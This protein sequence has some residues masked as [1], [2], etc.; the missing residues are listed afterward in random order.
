MMQINQLGNPITKTSDSVKRPDSM[1]SITNGSPDN[2][3][4]IIDDDV[5]VLLNS[6]LNLAVTLNVFLIDLK[7]SNIK[8]KSHDVQIPFE[9][10][11]FRQNLVSLEDLQKTIPEEFV[12]LHEIIQIVPNTNDKKSDLQLKRQKRMEE[13]QK[14]LAADHTQVAVKAVIKKMKVQIEAETDIGTMNEETKNKMEQISS[15][16][17]LVEAA[18]ISAE[19]SGKYC[20]EITQLLR[21]KL[22]MTLVEVN[23]PANKPAIVEEVKKPAIVEEVK[24]PVIVEEV[25]KPAIVE[26]VKKPVIV[27]EVKKP[28]AVEEVKKPAAVE[29]VKKPAIVEEVKKPA[30]VEEVKKPAIVEEVKKPA[31][32]EEVQQ[33]APVNKSEG[34]RTNQNKQKQRK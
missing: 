17:N 22:G 7:S 15:I 20:S 24:K 19:Q 30:I 4:K 33:K 2:M 31:V 32:V 25:K 34:Q 8:L 18:L 10:A 28:A 26:E 14:Y 16:I 3:Q 5:Y 29:E 11:R 1:T 9:I 23:A 6:T 13:K 21:N 12:P 27:E